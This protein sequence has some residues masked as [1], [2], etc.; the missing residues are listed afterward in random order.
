MFHEAPWP[1]GTLCAAA[2]C[3]GTLSQAVAA[4][5]LAALVAVAWYTSGQTWQDADLQDEPAFLLQLGLPHLA[6][7]PPLGALAALA[8]RRQ[9]PAVAPRRLAGQS[10]PLATAWRDGVVS[11]PGSGASLGRPTAGAGSGLLPPAQLRGHGGELQGAAARTA[12]LVASG[13]TGSAVAGEGERTEGLKESAP[14]V[15]GVCVACGFA[16]LLFGAAYYALIVSNY[17]KLPE[18]AWA[19]REAELLQKRAAPLAAMSAR[20]QSLLLS[21]CCTGPRAAHTFHSAGVLHYWAACLM[22]GL[23]PCCTL[24]GVGSLSD[25]RRRL[26]GRPRGCVAEGVAALLCGCCVVAQDA[27]TLDLVAGVGHGF[28]GAGGLPAGAQG[29]RR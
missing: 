20:W 22:M 17:P 4:A 25:L 26:G 15:S 9:A 24:W 19:P 8:A 16:Q 29:R 14:G 10:R 3:R 1:A 5:T 12:V 2:G 28:G 21:F 13:A 23:A 27:E 7:P 18:D 6:R 11:K